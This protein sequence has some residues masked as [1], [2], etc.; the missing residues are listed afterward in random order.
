MVPE[1]GGVDYQDHHAMIYG[2][3][4]YIEKGSNNQNHNLEILKYSLDDKKF[5]NAEVEA[6]TIAQDIQNKIKEHYLVY[7]M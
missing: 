5:T 7:I 2:N 1:L 4:A 3:L 6:F